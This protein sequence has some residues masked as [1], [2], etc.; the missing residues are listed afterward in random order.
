[1]YETMIAADGVGFAAPQVG[2][3]KQIAIVDVDDDISKIEMINPDIL[4]E[5]GIK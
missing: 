3:M 1:M 5:R 2:V 4:N